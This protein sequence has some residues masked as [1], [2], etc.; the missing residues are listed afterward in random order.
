MRAYGRDF[1]ETILIDSV[2]RQVKIII[3]KCFWKNVK[4]LLKNERC[5]SILLTT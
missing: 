5:L 4:I 2:F 1:D 3:L